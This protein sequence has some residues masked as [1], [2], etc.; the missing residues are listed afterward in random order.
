MLVFSDKFIKCANGA[1]ITSAASLIRP[2]GRSSNSVALF[3]LTNF[4]CFSTSLLDYILNMNFDQ[5]SLKF[6]GP[7]PT[8]V[9][10]WKGL[11]L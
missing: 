8:E 6:F 9:T 2:G 1:D 10:Q 4:S 11:L 3:L 7:F 5:F